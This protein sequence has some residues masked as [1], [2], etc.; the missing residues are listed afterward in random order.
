M[1]LPSSIFDYSLPAAAIAQHPAD[2]RDHSR[3][4][5]IYRATRTVEHRHFYEL[6]QILASRGRQVVLFRNTAKVIKA[7]MFLRRGTGAEIELLLLRPSTDSH[8]WWCLAKPLKK[9]TVGETLLGEGKP[10]ATLL[11]KSPTGEALFE[12]ADNPLTLS[13]RIGNLPLP[14]YIARA[15]HDKNEAEDS[16]RYQTVYAR[17]P[18]AAAAPTAGL[19]FTPELIHQLQSQGHR[20]TDLTLHVGLDTFRPISSETVEEHKIHTE[21]YEVGTE[22]AEILRKSLGESQA[23]YGAAGPENK[24]SLPEGGD[25]GVGPLRLAVGTTS[26]RTMEDFT[27]KGCPAELRQSASLFIYPPQ[28]LTSA[29]LLITNFHLPKSTLMC[30][31]S[32]FLTPG[33]LEGIAWLKALYAEALARGYRFYS[34]GDAMM[35]L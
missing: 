9:I 26:L 35:I 20:F 5:V 30:L 34:Y 19:H 15:P 13:E 21:T 31:V 11:E 24:F 7:R 14:P 6:P 8:K 32:A 3:L 1:P 22:A 25:Q 23:G 12:F 16:V 27:R 33:S 29:D 17:E 28:T 10:A 4:M 18:V 2:T